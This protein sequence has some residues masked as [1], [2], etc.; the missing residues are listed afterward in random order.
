[1]TGLPEWAQPLPDAEEQRAIDRWAI[2]E[3]GIA[4]I[5]LMERAGAGLTEL[6]AA[7]APDGAVAVVCGKGNNGGDGLVVARLLRE[8]GREAHVLCA[9]PIDQF[10]GDAR[11][12]LERLPGPAPALLQDAAAALEV[13]V[14]VVDALLGTGFEGS[15]HGAVAE[16]IETIGGFAAPVVSVDV[17]SGVNASTGVVVGV[18]VRAT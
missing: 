12:N 4:G 17:P 7:H 16:A 2:E 11:P 15:P 1:M 10:S 8:S 18:A 9:A 6:A 14:L 5:E 13:S 3:R